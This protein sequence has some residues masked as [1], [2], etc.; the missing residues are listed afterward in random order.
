MPITESYAQTFQ[1][2]TFKKQQLNKPVLI[3]YPDPSFGGGGGTQWS[4]EIFEVNSSTII[5]SGVEAFDALNPPMVNYREVTIDDVNYTLGEIYRVRIF[6]NTLALVDEW[7]FITYSN[8]FGG[9]GPIN[10]ALINGNIRRIAGLLG[11]NQVVTHDEHDKGVP[12]KTTIELYNGDPTD[13]GSTVFARYQ[14]V[15]FVDPQYR[16]DGEI[17]KRVL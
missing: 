2:H 5:G 7:Y 3:M 13:P 15:K 11:L 16:V 4:W 10:L 12:A 1:L 14:Q 17:S 6:N 9:T 8:D